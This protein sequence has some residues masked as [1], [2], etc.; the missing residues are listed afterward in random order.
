MSTLKRLV[1][2]LDVEVVLDII[3]WLCCI[4]TCFFDNEYA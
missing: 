2:M 1:G 4:I 3:E